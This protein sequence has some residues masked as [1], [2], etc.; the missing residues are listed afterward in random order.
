MSPLDLVR[1]LKPL[2]APSAK[3][4]TIVQVPDLAFLMIDGRGEPGASE[5][6][7][8][9][10]QALYSSAYTLKY[11]I[12]KADPQRDFRVM[13]LEGLWWT[14]GE[15]PRLD[16]LQAHRES[17]N[18][19]MMI[20]VPDFITAA[21]VI[22]AVGQAGRRRPLPAAD[23]VRLGRFDEGLAA[24]IMHIGPYA[25]EAPT[26]ERLHA[27]V[28]EQGYELRGRHHEIYMG[29]PNRTAPERLKTVLR[30]PVRPADEEE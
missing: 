18:W 17:W 14:E 20:A 1:E 29:D 5:A 19:T 21:D 10:L 11:S 13:P 23:R 7:Q 27:F 28:A 4:P 25:A 6:Y 8:E 24:Q 16:E 12:K 2:Y 22:D 30:H 9:A 26:I 15:P 3:H